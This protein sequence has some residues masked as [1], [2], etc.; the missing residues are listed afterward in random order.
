METLEQVKD[1]IILNGAVFESANIL[2]ATVGTTGYKGGD[3]G[4]GGRTLFR[5]KN[6]SC[7]DMRVSVNGEELNDADEVTI[8]FGGDCELDT[9]KRAL[10][11]AIDVLEEQSPEMSLWQRIKY[12]CKYRDLSLLRD[13]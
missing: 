5:L 13:L 7:T 4:H 6:R 10:R 8:V 12:A 3:T 9:F 2:E 11:F 1:K